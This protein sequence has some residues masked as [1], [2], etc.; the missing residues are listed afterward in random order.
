MKKRLC[1]LLLAG[2]MALSLLPGRANAADNVTRVPQIPEDARI[3]RGHDYWLFQHKGD[4]HSAQAY[5][6]SLG[7]HLATIT[8][9]EENDFLFEY[10]KS[11]GHSNA[12]FGLTDAEEEGVWKWVTGEPVEYTNW[13]SSEPNGETASEDWAMFYWKFSEGTWNDGGPNTLSGG[14]MYLCE[15]DTSEYD[16]KLWVDVIVSA[17]RKSD[18]QR[19]VIQGATVTLTVDGEVIQTR[20]TDKA[21][22]CQLDLRGLRPDQRRRAT[23]AAY[24]TVAVGK[25]TNLKEKD[26]LYAHYPKEIGNADGDGASQE[27]IRYEY[28]LRSEKIDSAGNWCGAGVPWDKDVSLK[29]T[30]SEPRI[31]YNISVCYLANDEYSR[32]Q[33]YKEALKTMLS[34]YSRSLAQATDGHAAIN[35]VLLFTADSRMDF[36]NTL[37]LAAM[38]DVHIETTEHDDGSFGWN[39]KIVSNASRGGFY[40]DHGSRI[41]VV[42]GQNKVTVFSP[43]ETGEDILEQKLFKHLKETE[44]NEIQNKK[45]FKRIQMSAVE[46]NKLN[47]SFVDEAVQYAATLTHESGHYLFGFLDEYQDKDGI[48][49]DVLKK[50]YKNFGLMD[51][52]YEDIEISKAGIDYAYFGGTF[53]QTGNPKHTQHSNY[54]TESCEDTLADFLVTGETLYF[55]V[56]LGNY[57][58]TYSKV[59]GTKDRTASYPWARLDQDDFLGLPNYPDGTSPLPQAED[60]ASAMEEM[61]MV[62][63]HLAGLTVGGQSPFNYQLDLTPAEGYT[64]A[65]YQLW[66]MT[67]GGKGF[68]RY[69]FDRN[70][71]LIFPAGLNSMT[72]LRL[73]VQREGEWVYN[74]YYIDRSLLTGSGYLYTSMDNTVMAYFTNTGAVSYTLLADNTAYTNGDYVSVNQATHVFSSNDGAITGGEIYSVA[75]CRAGI[76]YTSLSWFKRS[77]EGWVRLDTDRSA[78]ENKNIGARAD[79][80]GAGLYVLMARP[81][82]DTPAAPVTDLTWSQSDTVDARIGLTFT[83]PNT[84]SKYYNVYYSDEP[85]TDPKADHVMGRIYDADST[86]LTLDLLERGRTVY[87]GVEVVLE[88]GSRSELTMVQLTAGSADSDGDGIPDWYCSRHLLW[89]VDGEEK[90]IA[91]SDDDG[92]GFSNLQEYK[93]GTDPK[94]SGDP[95]GAVLLN[96]EAREENSV[97]LTYCV[98]DCGGDYSALVVAARY[99]GNGKLIR[100]VSQTADLAAGAEDTLTIRFP[101]GDRACVSTRVFL[102]D[103]K[104]GWA[105]LSGMCTISAAEEN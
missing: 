7:G 82:A 44:K 21:G 69:D 18:N 83:D 4:A 19:E 73:A 55:P 100:V 49:W 43:Y 94:D 74:T 8:S 86:Q 40:S 3:F 59:T 14:D 47:K 80:D 23:I 101:A 85:F 81:A 46:G 6:Q 34:E 87:A 103:E 52:Q 39:V 93:N 66:A 71:T 104:R 91:A 63:D 105:P 61:T 67:T 78:E 58:A 97:T 41:D 35:K 65:D 29:L 28:Q 68:T 45:T 22:F 75:S 84:D 60:D 62:S 54:Y 50:P 51:N 16:E 31:L 77:A 11:K 70:G 26:S 5:C 92:D 64:P 88:N 48:N 12:Y 99:D 9:K 13:H 102:L 79:L 96:G 57:A 36:Y 76:D 25:G 27:I 32:S 37:E 10:I 2:C 38:S 56:Q 89:P 53:P 42:N 1:S 90:D 95:A 98:G 30:L 72:E 17:V 20:T 33:E 15:W 24:K